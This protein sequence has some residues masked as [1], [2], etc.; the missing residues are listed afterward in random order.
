M[1]WSKWFLI[2]T[3]EN[4]KK[5]DSMI[6][7]VEEILFPSYTEELDSKGNTWIIDYSAD[8]NLYAAILDL[9]E[10]VVNETT[11]TTLESV[12]NSLTKIRNL[13]EVNQTIKN[14]EAKG[15]VVAPPSEKE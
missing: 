2:K 7:K 13:L 4:P 10:G 5:D 8:N 12:L 11:I 14:N 1:F 9:K 15:I 3:T 6:S